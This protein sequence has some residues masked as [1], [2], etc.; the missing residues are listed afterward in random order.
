MPR[1]HRTAERIVAESPAVLAQRVLEA[2][3]EQWTPLRAAV[4][5]ALAGFATPVSAYDLVEAVSRAQ[6]RRLAATSV[7]RILDVFT[8]ANLATRVESANA[9]VV[10]SHPTRHHDCIFLVCDGCGATGHLDDDP[11]V[12]R[13]RAAASA[14][15]FRV[16]R[17]V[18]ELHGRCTACAA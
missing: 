4:F 8:A 9:F 5:A 2:A 1:S 16:E 3:G 11:A 12:D 14:T 17:P 13:L 10:N 18:M 7:Y 6:G 15:G